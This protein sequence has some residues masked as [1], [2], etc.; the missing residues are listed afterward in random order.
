MF[1]T[2]SKFWISSRV[3]TC[4]FISSSRS[5]CINETRWSI[6]KGMLKVWQQAEKGSQQYFWRIYALCFTALLAKDCRCTKETNTLNKWKLN[7]A[8]SN[9]RSLGWSRKHQNK[10]NAL[11]T[12]A[13]IDY[14]EKVGLQFAI[15]HARNQ[16]LFVLFTASFQRLLCSDTEAV[17]NYLLTKSINLTVES[18]LSLS[19]GCWNIRSNRS[20]SSKK[21][22]R[23]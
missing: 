15:Q 4:C 19:S 10:T 11:L 14:S 18:P 9:P 3:K 7:H 13:E 22:K 12:A 16:I 8:E 1:L 6:F 20:F 2:W 21:D 17:G 5:W 23:D